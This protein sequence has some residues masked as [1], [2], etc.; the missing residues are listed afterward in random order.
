MK[1]KSW[2]W[3]TAV[4]GALLTMDIMTIIWGPLI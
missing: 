2:Q 3:T 1:L 4:G